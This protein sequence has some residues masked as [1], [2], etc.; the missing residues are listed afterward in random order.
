M[1]VDVNFNEVM[2]ME[3]HLKRLAL[4]NSAIN[5]AMEKTVNDLAFLARAGS[6]KSINHK[7]TTRNKFTTS[8]RNLNINK[9][10]R[11]KPFAELGHI[12]SYMKDQEL[13]GI[14]K[15]DRFY[16]AVPIPAPGATNETGGQRKRVIPKRH[17]KPAIRS[18]IVNKRYRDLPYKQRYW[19]LVKLSFKT[20]RPFYLFKNTLRKVVGRSDVGF[21][22]IKIF[23][24]QTQAQRVKARP[25]LKFPCAMAMKERARLYNGNL[26]YQLDRTIRFQPW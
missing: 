15:P 10:K 22:T 13:G 8:G 25:W 23:T 14:R 9:A 26:D 20:H 7:F 24:L 4:T 18:Q 11:G 3:D 19:A 1:K 17:R 6:V 5:I 21:K 16:N 12:Q 2:K